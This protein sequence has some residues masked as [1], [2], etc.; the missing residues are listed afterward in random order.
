M[1]G[2]ER[3]AEKK[4]ESI[5][6]AARE[7]FKAHGFKKVSLGDIAKEARVSHVTI[8]KYFGGKE[9]LVRDII[10]KIITDMVAT[11][12]EIIESDKPY[13]E[14]L[15]LL[16]LSKVNVGAQ[17]QGDLIK[18]IS[19]DLP[20]IKKFMDEMREKETEALTNKLIAEGK[21]LKYIKADLSARAINY[22]FM[23]IRNGLYTDKELLESVEIDKKLVH[24]LNYL[25]LFGLI[26]KQE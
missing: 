1:D 19:R 25:W 5:R 6:R 12:K 7:L 22:Y 3:R 11:S 18:A 9:E 4:K 23:I 8:Y 10:K 24:D 2:F 17:Y 21:R 16:I 15:N 13:L 14:K 26:E 20:E